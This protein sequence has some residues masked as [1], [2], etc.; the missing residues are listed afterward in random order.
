MRH[1]DVDGRLLR[2]PSRTWIQHLAVWPL[3]ARFP[4][5]EVLSER[6]ATELL[7]QWQGFDDPAILRRTMVELGLLWR[8]PDGREYRRIERAP[9]PEAKALIRLT[10]RRA[11][12]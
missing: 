11:T 4:R 6:Q 1:F 12:G 9:T 8:T 5:G 3:W 2:W 10:H 7:R